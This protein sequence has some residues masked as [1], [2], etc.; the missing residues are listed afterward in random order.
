MTT[1][2][3]TTDSVDEPVLYE[4]SERIATITINR[5]GQM[6]AIDAAAT[7]SLRDAVQRFESDE[8]AWVA[9]IT[10]AGDRAFCAGMDL[11][12]FAAGEESEILG[13]PGHFGGFV[14]A[15]TSKPIIAAVNGF[16]LA[17]GCEIV[18]ACDLVVAS[19]T[20][21]FGTPE[22]KRGIFAGAG[23]TFR[24]PRRLPPAIAMEML[25]TGDPI[26]AR[27][28]CDLGLVNRVVP[29]VDVMAEARTLAERITA[30]APLPVRESLRLA[31]SADDHP[32][33]DLWDQN[34]TAW[35][36]ISRTDDAAEGPRA[37]AE[38]RPPTWTGT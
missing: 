23:A 6:N 5:P 34:Q 26:D 27:V 14:R 12:A 1:T 7:R 30:N 16:A 32:E 24:L 22:V 18:L 36:R 35:N 13:G 19:E 4:L 29:A 11:K 8:D 2:S 10:G 9:I 28:A 15:D 25:L 33:T 37:F 31:R 17:G 20:A 3:D 38:K 21:R